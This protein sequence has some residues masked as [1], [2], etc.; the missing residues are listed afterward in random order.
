MDN[1]ELNSPCLLC[2]ERMK[3]DIFICICYVCDE[4]NSTKIPN[5]EILAVTF[6]EYDINRT[7]TFVRPFSD[8]VF[9]PIVTVMES[10]HLIV[11]NL[12]KCEI[13]C[14]DSN[15]QVLKIH[16]LDFDR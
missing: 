3:Y 9:F 15:Y 7:Y 10:V 11:E 16:M 6:N 12:F 2:C 5:V 8:K 13:I 4:I 1:N 14:S